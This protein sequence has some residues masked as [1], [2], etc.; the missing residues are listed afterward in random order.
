M[1]RG[2]L[3]LALGL[4]ACQTE[5][6]SAPSTTD[7]AARVG[8]A[9]L[10]EAAIDSALAAAPSDVDSA[11]ARREIVEPWIRRHLLSGAALA[12]GL[13]DDPKVRRRLEDARQAVL[14]QAALEHLAGDAR[15]SEADVEAY[16]A[17]HPADFTLDEPHVRVRTLRVAGARAEAQAAQAMAALA[18]VAASQNPDSTFALAAREFSADPAGSVALATSFVPEA[19]LAE[20]DPALAEA[21]TGMRPGAAPIAVPTGRTITVV[22]LA[23][24]LG[25]GSVLPLAAARA[26][27]AE[28]LG[29]S[30]RTEAAARLVERLRAEATARGELSVR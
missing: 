28:R 15:P 20:V 27:I 3:A 6:P 21:V 2:A 22:Q 5:A 14:E 25:A 24:R 7:A 23:E 10:T 16:Y 19:R 11:E 8:D 13:A 1:R 17:A 26:G 30:L 4:A 12:E 18:R 29:V 9:V